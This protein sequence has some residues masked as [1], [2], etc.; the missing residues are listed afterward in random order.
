M[1]LEDIVK[2]IPNYAY[3]LYFANPESTKEIEANVGTEC[4]AV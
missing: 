3:Q 4:G 1:S 2:M